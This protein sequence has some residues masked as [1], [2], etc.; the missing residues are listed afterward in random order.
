MKRIHVLGLLTLLIWGLLFVLAFAQPGPV[1]QPEG[2]KGRMVFMLVNLLLG[3]SLVPYL[4]SKLKAVKFLAGPGAII[5]SGILGIIAAMGSNLVFGPACP[6]I[7]F[8]FWAWAAIRPRP[9]LFSRF[10][11]PFSKR[12]NGEILARSGGGLRRSGYRWVFVCHP[13]SEAL[14]IPT[15]AADRSPCH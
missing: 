12:L 7:I 10:T 1:P 5:S 4:T 2:E 3:S 6:P 13:L 8:Y 15:G 9:V 11:R 14:P